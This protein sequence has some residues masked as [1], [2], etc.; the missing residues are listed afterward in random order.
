[1]MIRDE[2]MSVQEVVIVK[3]FKHYPGVHLRT[4]RKTS[5]TQPRFEPGISPIQIWSVLWLR[6]PSGD[7]G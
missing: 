3:V 4:L 6:N 2:Q 1:M 5:L 7:G